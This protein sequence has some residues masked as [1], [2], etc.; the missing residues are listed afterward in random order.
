[1]KNVPYLAISKSWV[2]YKQ[3]EL[4]YSNPSVPR[5]L[6]LSPGSRDPPVAPRPASEPLPLPCQQIHAHSTSAP[7]ACTSLCAPNQ[8]F[9]RSWDGLDVGDKLVC[10][11]KG[12][13]LRQH[14]HKDSSEQF[15]V[16]PCFGHLGC[17]VNQT[18]SFSSGTS[19]QLAC[20]VISLGWEKHGGPLDERKFKLMKCPQPTPRFWFLLF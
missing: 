14:H 20:Q 12:H 18:G 16:P 5:P 11:K 13:W 8:W 19:N 6:L 2:F 17:R 15:K 1:M 7:T 9:L 3:S 10:W 4:C